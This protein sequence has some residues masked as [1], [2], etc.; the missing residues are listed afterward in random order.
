MK[1]VLK[2]LGPL[3]LSVL[4]LTGCA[5][6]ERLKDGPKADHVD[7]VRL[8]EDSGEHEWWAVRYQFQWAPEAHPSWSLDLLTAQEIVWP[9][10][11]RYQKELPLWRF[12][13]RASR[14]GAGHQFSFIFFARSTVASNVFKLLESQKVH[15]G[16]VSSGDLVRV[17]F[18]A[19]AAAQKNGVGDTSD[20]KWPDELQKAWP[21]FIMGVSESWL[22]LIGQNVR[23]LRIESGR[24]SVLELKDA[25][26]EVNRRVSEQWREH[27]AHAF[28]HHLNA[29][30]G[31]EP[32]RVS[33][34]RLIRF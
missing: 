10:L 23:D 11:Q 20:P 31:Y 30:F 26:E 7:V 28:L 15:Q 6:M 27:G 9:A 22:A 2:R 5:G 21:W 32:F 3:L 19:F 18:G 4:I 29:V 25:Y 33:P 34:E 1:R 16:L 13:R 12:H 8:L 17:R 14:D 24:L